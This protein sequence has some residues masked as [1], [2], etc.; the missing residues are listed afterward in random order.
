M[1]KNAPRSLVN[2]GIPHFRH[3][4]LDQLEVI[5]FVV[6]GEKMKENVCGSER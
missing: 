4:V 6:I 2:I 3:T 1:V 5:Y